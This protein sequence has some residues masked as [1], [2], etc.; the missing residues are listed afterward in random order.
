M[1]QS[2][3]LATTAVSTTTS[4]SDDQRPGDAQP[5]TT[6]GSGDGKG[7]PLSVAINHPIVQL[8][9][10]WN[11]QGHNGAALRDERRRINRSGR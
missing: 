11:E 3:L 9:D 7:V 6:T 4:P 5:S 8:P 1:R 10:G 2:S